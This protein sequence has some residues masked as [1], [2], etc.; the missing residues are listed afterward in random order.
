[1]SK[2]LGF[3]LVIPEDH[4]V[5]PSWV[6]LNTLV[7]AELVNLSQQVELPAGLRRELMP[8]HVGLIPDGHRR[9]A[10]Q[11]GLSV[12]QGHSTIGRRLTEL[13]RLCDKWGVQVL[14][15]YGVSTE[16]LTRPK[17]EL[18]FLVSIFEEWVKSNMEEWARQN[19]RFSVI[20]NKS[21]LPR[22]IE[23]VLSEAE[24]ALKANS[25]LH[26][27]VALGYGGRYEILQA[28]K[29]V[30][31]KVKD[32]L[33]QL[34]DIDE[35]LFEQELQTKCTK[36]PSPDLLIRTGGECRV[37]NFMLWQLAYSEFYF[38]KT[39]FPN[40]GEADFIEALSSFQQRQRR[41]GGRS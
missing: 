12:Q 8:K 19:I 33:I 30:S 27:M 40:Y 1:M 11:R 17:E 9:W 16:T 41:Y 4:V 31:S 35:S 39:F 34:Q 29:S 23:Q 13:T 28:C 7:A 32:G 26:L 14:T 36:F 24:V 37:S 25:G 15:V 22:S 5:W 3:K 20:G 2:L 38:S 10:H 21:P 18:D 6:V